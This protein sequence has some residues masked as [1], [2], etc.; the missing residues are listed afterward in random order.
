MASLA[1][2]GVCEPTVINVTTPGN[3][4]TQVGD[5]KY[6]I[7]ALTVT[8]QLNGDDI[9]A[10]RDMAGIT[11][12]GSPTQGKLAELDLSG[13]SI[14]AGGGSYIYDYRTY[15]QYYT[16][17]N[18]LNDYT[19]YNCPALK[20]VTIPATVTEVGKWVFSVCANLTDVLVPAANTAFRSDNGVLISQADHKLI[21]FPQARTDQTYTVPADVKII[22]YEGF[23]DCTNLLSI[24]LPEGLKTIEGVAFTF[25]K[26]VAAFDIPA[27][28]D[29]IASSAFNYCS[30]L[31]RVNVPATSQAFSSV[32]GVLFNKAKTRL[33]RFPIGRTGEYTVPSGVLIIGEYAFDM[34][35]GLTKITLPEGLQSIEKYG[36]CSCKKLTELVLPNSVT[37]IGNAAFSGCQGLTSV[38]LP[39]E[40]SAL[41]DWAFESCK[42]LTSID[43][44]ETLTTFGEGTFSSC[45]ALTELTVPEGTTEIPASFCQS[46]KKLTKVTL[47]YTVAKIGEYAFYSCAAL[48]NFYCLATTPPTCGFWP[49]Y[50]INQE[51]CVLYVPQASVDTY[52]ADNNF[53][54]FKIIEGV[55]QTGLTQVGTDQPV[56]VA[57]Y[58]LNGSVA[59]AGYRG[60]TVVRMS[61]GTCRKELAQ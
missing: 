5:Q 31:Q 23:A 32:D 24:V 45:A 35:S 40:I 58:M 20:K 56:V 3:L 28:V 29:S 33:I 37:S 54:N 49:F 55:A 16:K 30:G 17:A 1:I 14:V 50:G 25:C 60:I 22:G 11:K 47:P 21:R 53:K 18:A 52:K 7:T 57:R 10:L 2:S 15:E 26:N 61:D 38:K 9:A 43:L 44:P 19:F 12:T 42:A 4:A 34:V 13:A 27:S 59:P 51:T 39:N 36:L 41:G 48:A 8:G 46:C 6:E